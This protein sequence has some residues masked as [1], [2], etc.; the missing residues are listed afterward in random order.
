MFAEVE[1]HVDEAGP[2]LS[3]RGERSGVIP[4]PHNPS[5][6]AQRPV[7][8]QR[9]SD[10]EAVH[11]AAGPAWLVPLDDEVPVVLLDRKVD[12]AKA[13]DGRPRDG[14]PERRKHPS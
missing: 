8:G 9:Q 2:H 4:V 7:D 1:K 12:H 10:R 13:I 11:A 3:R 5:L 14:A 6:A